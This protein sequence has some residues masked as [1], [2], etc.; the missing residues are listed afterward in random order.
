MENNREIW[1][2]VKMDPFSTYFEPLLGRHSELK[3]VKNDLRTA[4]QKISDSFRAGGKL[5]TCG[6]GGSAADSEHII[7][8][9][10]QPY[11]M[12]RPLPRELFEKFKN[13][14]PAD[15]DYFKRYLKGALPC[16]SLASCTVFLTAY[17]NDYAADMAYAQQIFACGKPCDVFLGITTSGR[18]KNIINAAKIADVLGLYVILLTS[19][20]AVVPAGLNCISIRVP[21]KNDPCAVQELHLPIYHA[22]CGMLEQEF[23]GKCNGDERI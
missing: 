17:C 15:A 10:M 11:K 13:Q 20:D 16:F 14:F 1:R 4:F 3:A 8:E 18:S 21:L 23:F 2:I 12:D 19:D 6:N 5:Y 9:L 22:L 7:S